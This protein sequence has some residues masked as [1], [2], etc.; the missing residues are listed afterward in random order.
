MNSK[1]ATRTVEIDQDRLAVKK[2]NTWKFSLICKN[3]FPSLWLCLSFETDRAAV[4]FEK[5]I[6]IVLRFSEWYLFASFTQ[7]SPVN[8]FVF[9]NCFG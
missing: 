2:K 5:K 1:P 3:K 8:S 6:K 9:C 4:N 7:N